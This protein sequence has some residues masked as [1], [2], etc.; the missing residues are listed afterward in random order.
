MAAVNVPEV[1]T[2]NLPPHLYAHTLDAI[3]FEALRGKSVAVIGS[4]ASAFDAAAVALEA[5]AREVHLFARRK[6]LASLPVIRQRI[7]R[8][9]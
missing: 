5:G 8:R 7:S 1:L 4:A 3:D 6:T 2:R 9:L